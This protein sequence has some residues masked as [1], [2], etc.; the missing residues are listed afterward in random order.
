MAELGRG[1]LHFP[2]LP[3]SSKDSESE[4][5]VVI[6]FFDGRI[7]KFHF[8]VAVTVAQILIIWREDI[9][10]IWV[11]RSI[12]QAISDQLTESMLPGSPKFDVVD[13]IQNVE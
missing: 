10:R 1:L 12:T 5:L 9:F 4:A 7:P 8:V 13:V 3:P 2:F 6:P 11:C